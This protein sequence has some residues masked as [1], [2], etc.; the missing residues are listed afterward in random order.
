MQSIT[1]LFMLVA[2]LTIAQAAN[3]ASSDQQTIRCQ[4]VDLAQDKLHATDWSPGFNIGT[5]TTGYWCNLFVA[6]VLRD[7]GAA[8]WKRIPE[9]V[10]VHAERDPVAAEW[11]NPHF[12]ISGWT[13]VFPSANSESL[14][15][16]EILALREPGDIVASSEHVGIV[17]DAK[18][19]ISASAKT[20]AVENNDWSYRLPDQK[21]YHDASK[22]EADAKKK[23][24]LFTVRRFTGK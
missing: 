17:S 14:T 4:I 21:N 7:A 18:K 12:A 13:V 20:G 19:V 22:Y 23:V 15:A 9:H 24:M 11:A 5:L 8:T 2:S 6:D 10:G 3:A 16:A 1:R